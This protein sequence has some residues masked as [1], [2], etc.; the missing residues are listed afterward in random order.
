M[1]YNAKSELLRVEDLFYDAFARFFDN[2]TPVELRR[3]LEENLGELP[4][5]WNGTELN[6]SWDGMSAASE[7]ER[8]HFDAVA[9]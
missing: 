5:R 3:L 1:A 7:L 8:P 4:A 9:L 6:G 2:P